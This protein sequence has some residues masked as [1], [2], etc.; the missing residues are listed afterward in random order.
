M[1][2]SIQLSAF[3]DE[4]NKLALFHEGRKYPSVEMKS[5]YDAATDDVH[6]D[7]EASTD[8]SPKYPTDH[9]SIK[10][11]EVK[12]V[13]RYAVGKNSNGRLLRV[14]KN[15][16]DPAPCYGHRDPIGDISHGDGIARGYDYGNG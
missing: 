14:P 10:T 9:L 5:E 2:S 8:N 11:A 15:S 3:N 4:L 7:L 16:A 6:E 13:A 1:I 12:W